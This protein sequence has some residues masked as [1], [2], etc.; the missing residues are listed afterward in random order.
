[1]WV[2]SKMTSPPFD[3]HNAIFI[4]T[5]IFKIYLKIYGIKHKVCGERTRQ[6]RNIFSLDLIRLKISGGEIQKVCSSDGS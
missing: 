6:R 1:M 4:F 3:K 2:F 5:L